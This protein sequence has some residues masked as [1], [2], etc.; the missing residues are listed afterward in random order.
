MT[1]TD[2]K[3]FTAKNKVITY[4]RKFVKFYNQKNTK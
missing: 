3:Q 4:T 2:S 1:I